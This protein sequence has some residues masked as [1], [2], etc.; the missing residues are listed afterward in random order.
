LRQRMEGRE[1]IHS[2]RETQRAQEHDV[3]PYETRASQG[4]ADDG[5]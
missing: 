4:S 5:K 3:T 1:A 2:N